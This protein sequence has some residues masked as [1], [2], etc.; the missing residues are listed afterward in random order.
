ML[1][2]IGALRRN[3]YKQPWT[4][5]L[6]QRRRSGPITYYSVATYAYLTNRICT[7]TGGK[8]PRDLWIELLLL[9]GRIYGAAFFGHTASSR[10]H[11]LARA[12]LFQ[13]VTYPISRT[14]YLCRRDRSM[15][16]HRVSRVL[17]LLPGLSGAPHLISRP[18]RRW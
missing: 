10:A 17:T 5:L 13:V 16:T 4:V 12:A 7:Y 1:Y 11:T 2:D 3:L 14:L 18:A 8:L 9:S 15:H 6:F